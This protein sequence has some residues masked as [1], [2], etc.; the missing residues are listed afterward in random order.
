MRVQILP[1][2]TR[3][4]GEFTET[5]FV[6][7]LDGPDAHEVMRSEDIEQLR[8]VTG[9]TA[10]WTSDGTIDVGQPLTLT[11]EQTQGILARL[12]AP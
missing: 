3:T 4:V 8:T 1:L 12:T 9:A 6:L 5:P 10:V 7:I 2:P 11:E